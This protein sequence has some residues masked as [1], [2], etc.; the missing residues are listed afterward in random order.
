MNHRNFIHSPLS[1]NGWIRHPNPS[2]CGH[3]RRVTTLGV[4]GD[5]RTVLNVKRGWLAVC[6]WEGGLP[7]AIDVSDDQSGFSMSCET[8]RLDDQVGKFWSQIK[9]KIVAVLN[10]S[11]KSIWIWL[12][13]TA[14]HYYCGQWS[15]MNFLRLGSVSACSYICSGKYWTRGQAAHALEL[16]NI[17]KVRDSHRSTIDRS[18]A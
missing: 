18:T 16:R 15:E 3:R 5:L 10:E 11:A 1:N 2:R 8:W 7:K 6:G 13:S 4:V 17:W 14:D 12:D 9:S